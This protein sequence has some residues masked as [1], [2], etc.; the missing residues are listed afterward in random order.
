[1]ANVNPS[2]IS[3]LMVSGIL[4]VMACAFGLYAVVHTVFYFV[5]VGD[6]FN[7]IVNSV[8][9]VGVAV[10]VSAMLGS[11]NSK[12]QSESSSKNKT[13]NIVAR[14]SVTIVGDEVISDK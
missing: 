4:M 13:S 2:G 11:V 8:L 3:Q 9:S 5:G 6:E 7:S 12:K 14:G 10:A 1:M